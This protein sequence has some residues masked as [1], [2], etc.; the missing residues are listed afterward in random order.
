MQTREQVQPVRRIPNGPPSRRSL[1]LVLS[2]PPHSA[3]QVIADLLRP[4]LTPT[5]SREE[6]AFIEL[7]RGC[8]T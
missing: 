4:K 5:R 2:A 7:Q 3:A 8:P 1:Q 6:Q